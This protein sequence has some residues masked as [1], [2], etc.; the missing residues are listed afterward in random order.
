MSASVENAPLLELIA[1]LRWK[2]AGL[3]QE[4]GSSAGPAIIPPSAKGLHEFFMRFGAEVQAAGYTNVMRLVPDPFPMLAH[5][6]VYRFNSQ[7]EGGTKS[8]YQVGPGLFSANAVPP[9]ESWSSFGPIVKAGVKALLK[10]RDSA[11]HDAQFVGATLRY[12][13]AFGPV[14]TEGRDSARFIREVLGI[15][16]EL[17]PALTQHLQAGAAWKPFLQFHIPVR[18]GV[19]LA[20][21]IGDGIANDAPAILMDTSVS[22]SSALPPE[23]VAL[24]AAFDEAHDL[25]ASAFKNLMA[26]IS[27]LMPQKKKA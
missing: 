6:P 5:Q 13:D 20:L 22:F 16:I 11:E 2:P 21:A 23:P 4:S 19:L 3:P 15:Q 12:L 18:P 17:P 24:M 26:P 8:L 27:H 10:A 25:I 7:N 14:L 9:Y 1:E